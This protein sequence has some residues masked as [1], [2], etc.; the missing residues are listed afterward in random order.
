MNLPQEFIDLCNGSAVAVE[1]AARDFHAMAAA[2]NARTER[3]PATMTEVATYCVTGGVVA[4]CKVTIQKYAADP[5][6]GTIPDALA[7]LAHSTIELLREDM[8]ATSCDVDDPRFQAACAGLVGAG[9]MSQ[10]QSDDLAALGANRR[11]KA[12]AVLGREC[13]AVDCWTACGGDS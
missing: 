8:R 1:R 5:S 2:L 12:E 10:E 6:G 4:A 7:G 9:L 3:G 13:S 11:G